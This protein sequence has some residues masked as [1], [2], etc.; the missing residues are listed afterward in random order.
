M[1]RNRRLARAVPDVG[2]GE[3]VRQ[4]QYKTDWYG[5]STT[6]P[7]SF[8]GDAKRLWRTGEISGESRRH[9]P[10]KQ[11]R[12]EAGTRVTEILRSAR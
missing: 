11:K 5:S 2:F 6:S 7:R 1:V 3:F 10:V 4:I 8:V 9:G 12:S